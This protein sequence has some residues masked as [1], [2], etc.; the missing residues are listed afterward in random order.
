MNKEKN[1]DSASE[2]RQENT[3]PTF[4]RE[5]YPYKGIGEIITDLATLTL[6]GVLYEIKCPNCE[7]SIRSQGSNVRRVYERMMSTNGCFGC[8][9]KEMTIRM[10]HMG[11]EEK[12]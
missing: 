9:S 1:I 6:D 11:R 5:D 2:Q 10:V 7:M 4:L 12:N 8:G 3:T